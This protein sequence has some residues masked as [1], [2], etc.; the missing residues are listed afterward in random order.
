MASL[1]SRDPSPSDALDRWL[2]DVRSDQAAR[3]R[4]RVGA[5]RAHAAE[6]ATLV[7][8]LADLAERRATAVVTTTQGRRHRV[9]VW[10]VGPDAVVFCAGHDEWLVVRLTCVASVRL[11]G[12]DPVHGEGSMTMTAS[13]GRILA[14]AAEPGDRLRLVLGGEVVAGEVVSISAEVAV[15]RL[16]S[17]DLSYVALG[18]VEEAVVVRPEL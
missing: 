18:A 9:E 5:L 16:D 17:T 6:D 11:V 1:A 15:L 8:V 3:S 2:G 12:G 13:F 4:A 14:R 7:G 10:A